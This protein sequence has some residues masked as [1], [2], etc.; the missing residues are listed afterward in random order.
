MTNKHLPK[1]Q[2]ETF[3]LAHFFLLLYIR[4]Y[5]PVAQVKVG[6]LGTGQLIYFVKNG[7]TNKQ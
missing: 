7:L 6:E 2:Q 3:R 4:L 1:R 5:L